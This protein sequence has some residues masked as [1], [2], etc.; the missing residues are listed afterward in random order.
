MSWRRPK[1]DFRAGS[2]RGNKAAMKKLMKSGAPVGILLYKDGEA[3]G[4]CSVAPRQQFVALG[5]SR[6]WAPVDDQ[7]VWSVSCFFLSKS[8]RRQGLSVELLNAAVAFAKKHGAKIVE[9]Y[10]QDL[11]EKTLP[12]A[13]VWT[14]LQKSYECADFR[15]AVR[16]SKAKPIMRRTVGGRI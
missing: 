5:N 8:A 14:G 4:W 15:E 6:V 3:V 9:G 12:A 13:F 7:P 16:R 11:G 10:P 2:G 1:K